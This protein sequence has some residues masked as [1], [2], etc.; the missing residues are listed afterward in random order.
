MGGNKDT[1][2]AVFQQIKMRFCNLNVAD[3]PIQTA[4]EGK[5]GILRIDLAVGVGDN[6][7]Q[8]IVALFHC[9]RQFKTEG[10]EAALV[11]AQFPSVQ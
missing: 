11:G 9:L 8:L 4:V 10:G 7:G 5:V 2:G 3:I 1:G 6:N